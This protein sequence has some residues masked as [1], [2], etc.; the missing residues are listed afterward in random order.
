MAKSSETVDDYISA[1]LPPVR[2]TLE[3]LRSLIHSA[4]PGAVES[5]KWGAPVFSNAGGEVVI[6]LYGGKDHANLGFVRGVELED[7]E[8]LLKGHGKSGRHIKLYPNQDIP[9]A[10]MKALVKQCAALD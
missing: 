5:M 3:I 4:L 1:R 8:G 7:P 9:E 6:Y 10:A 2:A